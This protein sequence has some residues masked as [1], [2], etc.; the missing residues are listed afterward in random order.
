MFKKRAGGREEWKG[1]EKQRKR[2]KPWKKNN[3]NMEPMEKIVQKKG[4]NQSIK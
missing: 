2:E 3:N 4:I 1:Q